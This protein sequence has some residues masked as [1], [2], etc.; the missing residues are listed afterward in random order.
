M[1]PPVFDTL[2][3]DAAVAAL[4]SDRIFA[5]GGA[6]QTVAKPYVTWQLIAGVPLNNLSDLPPGDALTV[7]VDC[8]HTTAAGIEA[9]ATA[10]RDAIEPVAHVTGVVVNL[11][12]TATK[13][14]RIGMQADWWL[15]R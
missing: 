11:R 4:V 5:H 12:E 7:Q 15:S 6:P 14:Y 2:H 8:W 10:V 3:G 13:L 1:L 9:L